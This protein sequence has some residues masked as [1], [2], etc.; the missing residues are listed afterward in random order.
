[1]PAIVI[2]IIFI[3]KALSFCFFCFFYV[4]LSYA[5]TWKKGKWSQR[6]DSM[7]QLLFS[8]CVAPLFA[9]WLLRKTLPS[10]TAGESVTVS[11]NTR[12]RS[13]ITWVFHC[14]FFGFSHE[15]QNFTFIEIC[16][17]FLAPI[18]SF[19]YTLLFLQVKQGKPACLTMPPSF[20]S[21]WSPPRLCAAASL[22]ESMRHWAGVSR[23]R[24]CWEPGGPAVYGVCGKQPWMTSPP[25][26]M[27]PAAWTTDLCSGR[28]RHG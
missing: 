15:N 23:R 19:F 16:V 8:S 7:N 3:I 17:V 9:G 2:I 5:H 18:N 1:M 26:R 11:N 21:H 20:P 12:F 14:S 6:S 28:P 24:R 10:P 13:S 22:L 25:G 4:T 27:A